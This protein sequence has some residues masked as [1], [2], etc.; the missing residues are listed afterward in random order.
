V[1]KQSEEIDLKG[2]KKTSYSYGILVIM[3]F[4][5]I[6]DIHNPEVRGSTPLFATMK[7][8]RF[9]AFSFL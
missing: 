8:P 1:R 9:G 5:H 3:G 2:S 4:E 6:V 7:K